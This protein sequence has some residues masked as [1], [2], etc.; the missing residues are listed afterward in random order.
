MASPVT[1]AEA[2]VNRAS[3]FPSFLRSGFVAGEVVKVVRR[4]PVFF[5][6]PLAGRGGEGR[7]WR[8]SVVRFCCRWSPVVSSGGSTPAGRGG[9][10]SSWK[11]L[12]FLDLFLWQ[13]RTSD[14]SGIIDGK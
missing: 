3:S 11:G 4:A 1:V 7:S 2:S 5:F 8:E 14:T 9:E 12:T 10:G 13:F 6:V